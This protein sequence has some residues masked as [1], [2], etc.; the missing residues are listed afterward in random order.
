LEN[1]STNA[2][3]TSL[4]T[5]L[6]ALTTGPEGLGTAH[7]DL[8]R[9]L[10]DQLVSDAEPTPSVIAGVDGPCQAIDRALDELRRLQAT[11]IADLNNVRGRAGLKPLPTWT[12]P[13][14]PACEPK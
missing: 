10:N 12:A 3:T 6:R 11:T 4:D 9:R 13:P 5:A 2:D 7:R 1:G 14:A 8:G